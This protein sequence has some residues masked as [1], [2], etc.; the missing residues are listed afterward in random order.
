MFDFY[1]GLP[2]IKLVSTKTTN[3]SNKPEKLVPENEYGLSTPLVS[4]PLEGW[5]ELLQHFASLISTKWEQPYSIMIE[6]LS[7]IFI[8][9]FR[10]H[11]PERSTFEV[12]YVP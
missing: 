9:S 4:A 10:S 1:P 5:E 11:V 3:D 12:S 2:H 6:W 8:P 7:F